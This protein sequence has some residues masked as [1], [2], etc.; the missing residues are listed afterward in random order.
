MG[1]V[2]GGGGG[3]GG[4]WMRGLGLNTFYLARSIAG[5]AQIGANH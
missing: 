5:H 4:E 2:C 1:R 3:G